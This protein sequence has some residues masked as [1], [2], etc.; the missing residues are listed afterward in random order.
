M[1]ICVACLSS[2]SVTRTSQTPGRRF[3]HAGGEGARAFH[4]DT[5]RTDVL[6]VG[7]DG[8]RQD[9]QVR[10]GPICRA[11][12]FDGGVRG[13]RG[14]QVAG[15][16]GDHL[17][18]VV[19][20]LQRQLS[21][22]EGLVI[23]WWTSARQKLAHS[24]CSGPHSRIRLGV[25]PKAPPM[26]DTM[27]SSCLTIKRDCRRSRVTSRDNRSSPQRSHLADK[28]SP[29]ASRP[30]AH[31]RRIPMQKKPQSDVLFYVM[32]AFWRSASL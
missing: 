29:R 2:A 26:G 6:A 16:I 4:G 19:A 3:L 20:G 10:L 7:I 12:E 15:V 13:Q 1:A 25:A 18:D 17:D 21:R 27:A 28:R 9:M 31:P 24:L 30:R 8:D 5:E 22:E 23:I 32:L 14:Q 11:R